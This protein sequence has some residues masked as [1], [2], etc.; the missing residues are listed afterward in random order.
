MSLFLATLQAEGAFGDGPL[1]TAS[2]VTVGQSNN[3]VA[4]MAAGLVNIDIAY[5]SNEYADEYLEVHVT[6]Q[7]GKGL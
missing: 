6:V 3:S 2:F 1:Q 7:A 5:R 4:D